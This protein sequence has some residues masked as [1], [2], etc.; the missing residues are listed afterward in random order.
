MGVKWF[1]NKNIKSDPSTLQIRLNYSGKQKNFKSFIE[2]EK[3]YW[4]FKGKRL[5]KTAPQH[6]K[7]QIKETEVLIE[8]TIPS[9][10][11]N[12][13]GGF[14]PSIEEIVQSYHSDQEGTERVI[15][16]SPTTTLDFINSY[17]EIKRSIYTQKT[18]LH[19]ERLARFLKYW[20]EI[21]QITLTPENTNNANIQGFANWLANSEVDIEGVKKLRYE[22]KSIEAML[23]KLHAVIQFLIDEGDYNGNNFSVKRAKKDFVSHSK[24]SEVGFLTEEEVQELMEFDCKIN[25]EVNE[26]WLKV[27]DLFV[28]S[29]LNGLRHSEFYTLDR[30]TCIVNRMREGESYKALQY[31]DEKNKGFLIERALSRHSLDIIKRW[32]NHLNH[33]IRTVDGKK[34]HLRNLLLPVMSD[35]KANKYLH[36][37]LREIGRRQNPDGT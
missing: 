10:L 19:Y 37:I 34:Q 9:L 12:N 8:Q 16:T 11:K 28:F 23:K 32:G 7:N 5:K 31:Y 2:V 27:R 20:S 33:T 25:G 22:N 17:I 14:K 13:N 24:D 15:K 30:D 6:L 4:D 29:C 3:R 26:S 21:N 36:E 18:V 1:L 35:Q